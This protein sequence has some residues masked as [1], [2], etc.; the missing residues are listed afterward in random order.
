MSSNYVLFCL[1]VWDETNHEVLSN[2]PK[3]FRKLYEHFRPFFEIFRRLPK[4]SEEFL[5]ISKDVSTAEQYHFARLTFNTHL[6][7]ANMVSKGNILISSLFTVV[8][9]LI[10]SA[11]VTQQA[12]GPTMHD[13]CLLMRCSL[14]K[15][16]LNFILTTKF[17]SLLARP[18]ICAIHLFKILTSRTMENRSLVAYKNSNTAHLTFVVVIYNDNNGSSASIYLWW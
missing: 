17:F 14:R 5:E 7:R 15:I 6:I 16:S 2:F 13:D 4:I 11:I 18:T 12:F 8:F 3:I 10:V 1:L 9:R